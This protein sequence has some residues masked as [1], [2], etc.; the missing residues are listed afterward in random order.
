VG[1]S[2]EAIS[3]CRAGERSKIEA[4]FLAAHE[5]PAVPGLSENIVDA[6]R[7]RLRHLRERVEELALLAT[8]N[9]WPPVER[10]WWA[11][12]PEL[13]GSL[14]NVSLLAEAQTGIPLTKAE[15]SIQ[16]GELDRILMNLGDCLACENCLQFSDTLDGRLSP[17][18]W[19]LDTVLV[20][21]DVR[22]RSSSG[23]G[24][25][26]VETSDGRG[27][28]VARRVRRRAL[29]RSGVRS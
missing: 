20:K 11:L 6:L 7:A 21:P 15:L 1:L 19:N 5:P 8:I 23:A 25:G 17:W 26:A 2:I 10:V 14:L 29:V 12:L 9:E 24:P 4:S 27:C 18:L 22:P 3:V 16:L 13:R 28:G